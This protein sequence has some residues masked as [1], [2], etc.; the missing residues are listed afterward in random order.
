M[1]WRACC[2]TLDRVKCFQYPCNS[3]FSD[4][5]FIYMH[6]LK[7]EDTYTSVVEAIPHM[8]K[9]SKC[10]KGILLS[11]DSE[12]V[13]TSFWPTPYQNSEVLLPIY[14]V[15]IEHGQLLWQKMPQQP[16]LQQVCPDQAHAVQTEPAN[17]EAYYV[18]FRPLSGGKFC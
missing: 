18:R 17:P 1:D 16:S 11:T 7:Q 10:L 9:S 2:L 12:G 8:M 6:P 3:A 15:G 4:E 13:C 14:I 5:A